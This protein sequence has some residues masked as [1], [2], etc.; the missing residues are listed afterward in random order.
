MIQANVPVVPGYHGENQ[1]PIY[2]QEQSSKM[3]YPVLIKAVKGG[4]GKG[5]RIVDKEEDFPEMLASSKREAIKHFSDDKVLI[6]KYIRR[7]RHVEVQVF[8]DKFGDAVY[9]FERDCS[10]QRRHQKVLEEAPAPNITEELRKSLGEKAVAA[11]K[12]VGY[13]GAGTVEFILDCDTNEFYFMEMNTRLQVEHPITE[14]VTNTDLVE[15]QLR[16]AAG[17]PLPLKQ[18]QIKLQGH[19]FEAR[20]YAENPDNGF[21]PDT[22]KL[23]HYITPD[24][25]DKVRVETG[26]RQND[27]VS[28]HYDPMISKLVTWGET[29]ADAL[30]IM[31]KTLSETEVVGPETN[32]EFLKKLCKHPAFATGEVDTSFIEV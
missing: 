20:V 6:E 23:I 19:A 27:E 30:R 13:V 7:S 5:M 21:M 3:G 12:A 8:G 26:V 29:R 22:G 1:D 11:A 2:L 28:V 17:N 10:V 15:W 16:V 4:G 32:V 24:V 14:M 31:H 18:D 25:T 9:L